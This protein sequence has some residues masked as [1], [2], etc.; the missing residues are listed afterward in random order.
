VQVFAPGNR[1]Y[2]RF[3]GEAAGPVALFE[4]EDL[5]AAR[6]KLEAAGVELLGPVERDANWE[7]LHFRAPD[8]RIYDLAA[9]RS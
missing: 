6:D 1:F 9:R 3:G 4:V 2:E 5:H 7:W 8:G